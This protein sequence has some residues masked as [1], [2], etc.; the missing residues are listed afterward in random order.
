VSIA[1]SLTMSNFIQLDFRCSVGF[2]QT[3]QYVEDALCRFCHTWVYML[4]CIKNFGQIVKKLPPRIYLVKAFATLS[5][6]IEKSWAM[7]RIGQPHPTSPS[8]R[9][10]RDRATEWARAE[11]NVVEISVL[12]VPCHPACSG[13]LS[14]SSSYCLAARSGNYICYNGCCCVSPTP[15]PRELGFYSVHGEQAQLLTEKAWAGTGTRREGRS[16]R[17][18]HSR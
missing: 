17:S 16:R 9:E 6:P 1:N 2:N 12:I 10:A 13:G 5:L 8:R 4:E 18:S 11:L 3:I 14:G 15:W 7:E